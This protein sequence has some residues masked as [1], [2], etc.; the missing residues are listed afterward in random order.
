MDFLVKATQEGDPIVF[1]S[2]QQLIALP[3][4]R[5]FLVSNLISSAVILVYFIYD[6]DGLDST[7]R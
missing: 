5:K 7:F 2:H 4:L 6:L 3:P 1:L